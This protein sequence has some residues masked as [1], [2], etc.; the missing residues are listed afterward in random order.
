[1]TPVSRRGFVA[2]AMAV[3]AAAAAMRSTAIA[4]PGNAV[5]LYDA[6]LKAGARFATHARALGGKAIRL[7][8]DRVRQVRTLLANDPKAIF[9]ISRHSDEWLVKD[10]AAQAGYRQQSLIQHRTTGDIIS[11]CPPEG[12]AIATLA[13]LACGRWP[14]AFAELAIGG[15]ERC[16]TLSYP[17]AAEPAFSWVLTRG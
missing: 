7:E 11:F 6:D 4:Q 15:I 3:T 14:E 10:V 8:G 9:G 17:A 1:M 5:L 2:G 16:E 13:R 12:A